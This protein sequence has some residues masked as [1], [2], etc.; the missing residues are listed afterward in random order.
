[1][2]H[3]VKNDFDTAVT[4]AGVTVAF[5]PTNSVY[6]F[7]RLAESED[8]ARLGPVSLGR[9]RHAGPS[10]DTKDYGPDEVQDMAQRIAAEA[11][12]SVWSAQDEKEAD[13][14]TLRPYS[15][16]GDDDVIE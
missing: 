12:A 2:K 5:K 16:G 8:I 13:K 4:E 10:G 6:S 1:M 9:V 7:Y 11:G 15:I 3:P 14:S